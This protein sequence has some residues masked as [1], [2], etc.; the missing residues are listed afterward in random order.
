LG[1]PPWETVYYPERNTLKPRFL[2]YITVEN[3][4]ILGERMQDKFELG[5]DEEEQEDVGAAYDGEVKKDT[6]IRH[7]SGCLRRK[8]G[9]VFKGFF[10]MNK[11]SGLG[12]F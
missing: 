9:E 6:R 8:N 7:G 12:R 11:F 10:H 1:A 5:D 2:D 3:K 4:Q